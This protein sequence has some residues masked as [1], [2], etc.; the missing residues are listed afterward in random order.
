MDWLPPEDCKICGA[1]PKGPT[2]AAN[3]N[4]QLEQ[5]EFF[6]PWNFLNFKHGLQNPP[7]GRSFPE[8]QL[9]Y[10]LSDVT[11]AQLVVQVRV[12]FEQISSRMSCISQSHHAAVGPLLVSLLGNVLQITLPFLQRRECFG[13]NVFL[14]QCSLQKIP[15]KGSTDCYR[16]MNLGFGSRKGQPRACTLEPEITRGQNGVEHPPFLKKLFLLHCCCLPLPRAN[17][18]CS[19]KS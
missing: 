12:L 17:A 6:Q 15:G 13:C 10:G 8:A 14:C 18:S 19:D 4:V 11:P 16:L 5:W 9:T 3:G 7:P 2:T 1:H